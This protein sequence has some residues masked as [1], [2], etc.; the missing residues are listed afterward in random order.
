MKF[1]LATIR[2]KSQVHKSQI[3]ASYSNTPLRTLIIVKKVGVRKLD[4]RRDTCFPTFLD[5]LDVL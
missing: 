2:T 3:T 1:N 4:F 5:A